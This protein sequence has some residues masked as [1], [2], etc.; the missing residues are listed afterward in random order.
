[1]FNRK[2]AASS[3]AHASVLVILAGS[4]ISAV[5]GFRGSIRLSPGQS[6]DSFI[7]GKGRKTLP[8]VI[9][10]ED[11]TLQWYES[12]EGGYPVRVRVEDADFTGKYLVQPGVNYQV[13]QTGY[14]FT[15]I[16]YLPYFI[17]DEENN[18]VSRSAQPLNPAILVSV[19]GPSA[20][21]ER[22]VFANYPEIEMGQDQNIRFRFDF[23]PQIKEYCSRVR[24]E[25]RKAG[26]VF[27]RDIKVNKP[28]EYRGYAIYQ[29][30]YDSGQLSWSGLDI[31]YDP[32]VK[33]V[34]LGFILM[35][36]GIICILYPK[37]RSIRSTANNKKT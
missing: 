2:K 25:D 18:S 36:A 4:L 15:V 17:F 12:N 28:L 37:L 23:Q 9:T 29:S 6:T 10:L 26:V 34:F 16:R 31:V 32:G 11:F 22:W 30:S 3:I 14:S 13:G 24:I 5:F 1:L 19:N 35:N 27:S 33:I 8:F 7:T 20:S 21:Y